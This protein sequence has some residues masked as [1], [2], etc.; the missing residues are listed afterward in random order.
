[1]L[2][3]H[4]LQGR[5]R[6][7]MRAR[8][9]V[10]IMGHDRPL[11]RGHQQIQLPPNLLIRH[12]PVHPPSLQPLP[13]KQPRRSH[14]PLPLPHAPLHKPVQHLADRRRLPYTPCQRRAHRVEPCRR[15]EDVLEL[16]DCERQPHER[17]RA[18][19][20]AVLRGYDFEDSACLGADGIGDSTAGRGGGEDG[21]RERLEQLQ[22]VRRA[23]E[24]VLERLPGDAAVQGDE[25]V[26]GAVDD[27]VGE[28]DAVVRVLLLGLLDVDPVWW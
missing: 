19:Q 24:Q 14:K 20:L 1:M 16:R 21:P 17:Q 11:A 25:R 12:R 15:H 6:V 23:G 9:V 7:S 2:N 18:H 26:S 4:P 3:L 5:L 22:E 13:L 28:G 10:M 27:E 8:W